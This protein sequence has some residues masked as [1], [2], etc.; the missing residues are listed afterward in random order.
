ML[1]VIVVL[2]LAQA[3]ASFAGCGGEAQAGRE[4]EVVMFTIENLLVPQEGD[5]NLL[6]GWLRKA[7][8]LEEATPEELAQRFWKWEGGALSEISGEDYA[9]LSAMREGGNTNSWTYSQHSVTVLNLD[10]D[11]GQALVEVGSLY[12]PVSG[13][14]VRYLLRL[15]EGEWVKVSEQT[16][17]TT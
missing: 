11:E 3:A 2:A 8:S 7:E 1:V 5:G 4:E 6:I 13:K 17:W 10:V 9:S 12:G 15:E 16:I 14:G